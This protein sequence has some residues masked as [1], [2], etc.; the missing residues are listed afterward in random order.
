M[1]QFLAF[2]GGTLIYA[3]SKADAAVA[4][5]APEDLADGAMGIFAIGNAGKLVLVDAA[6]DLADVERIIF[7]RGLAVGAKLSDEFS[8]DTLRVE[9]QA[10]VASAAQV[11]TVS[12]IPATL[13]AGT[14][15]TVQI[16]D[17]SSTIPHEWKWKNHEY[18][19]VAA[20]ETAA[21]ISAALAAKI[22][23]KSTVATA[24]NS[25][26]NLVITAKAGVKNISVSTI[27]LTGSTVATTTQPVRSQGSTDRMTA[28]QLECEGYDGRT[29]YTDRL[30][31]PT[32]DSNLVEAGV[33][34]VVYNVSC[35]RRNIRIAVPQEGTDR[36][37]RVYLA[38]PTGATAI[39]TLDTLLTASALEEVAGQ[40]DEVGA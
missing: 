26:G 14:T 4:A 17:S 23:A 8:R 13:P 1:K 21:T 6:A 27:G 11:V 36:F 28:L 34:Y 10:Y 2:K 19:T 25:A 12:G 37:L 16:T 9:K 35:V 24:A 20:N 5:T 39:T 22:T 38:I 33:N 30:T 32:K 29:N 40:A 15:V 7:A 3:A 18:T 31:G